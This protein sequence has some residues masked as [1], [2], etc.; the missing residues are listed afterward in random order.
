[1]APKRSKIWKSPFQ[2]VLDPFKAFKGSVRNWKI[3]SKLARNLGL[4]KPNVW[5]NPA[6]LEKPPVTSKLKQSYGKLLKMGK[7]AVFS[8]VRDEVEKWLAQKVV[9]KD[10]LGPWFKKYTIVTKMNAHFAAKMKGILARKRA[11]VEIF[12]AEFPNLEENLDDV[13]QGN[14]QVLET[15]QGLP[16]NQVLAKPFSGEVGATS[17]AALI[18][19]FG[20]SEFV[21]CR[22][23]V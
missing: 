10:G 7:K 17:D 19:A 15:L 22:D 21:P 20:P 23:T 1:M 4:A 11:G 3:N 18:Q 8:E 12:P 13:V 9:K 2:H 14:G 16:L 6:V 5:I